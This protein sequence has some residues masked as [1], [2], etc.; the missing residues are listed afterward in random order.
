MRASLT[1]PDCSASQVLLRLLCG[2][3]L[4]S[5]LAA[6]AS[7]QSA[8]DGT[9]PAGLAPGSPAG[10]YALSDFDTVN[11]YNG[12]LNVRLPLL[13]VGG[14]GGA[15]YP[16]T[17]H[18]EQKWTVHREKIEPHYPWS[19]WAEPGWWSEEGTGWRTFDAG[20]LHV[21]RGGSENFVQTCGNYIHAKT[22]SRVTFSA[23]DGTEYELRDQ[24]TNGQPAAPAGCGPGFNRGRVFVTADGT[25]ATYVSDADVIDLY[26]YGEDWTVAPTSGYLLLRDGTRY[27][28]DDGK[29][30]WMRDRNGNLLTFTYDPY[31]RVTGVADSLGRQVTITYPSDGV[32]YTEIR[33]SGSGGAART[34]RVGQTNLGSALRSDFT[35]Q[36][37]QQLFPELNASSSLAHDPTVI[38]YVELPDGRRYQ[39]QYN[40]YGEV[41]RVV[42]PTGGAVE[43]DHAAG[44]TDGAASGVF[45]I[46]SHKYVYRR[47]VERR[48][49]PGGGTGTS[50]ASRMTYSRPETTGSNLGYVVADQYDAGGTLLGRS[51]HHYHGSPRASFGLKPTDYPAWK[52]GREYKTEVFGANGTTALRR[53]EHTFAQRAAVG[54]W[55]GDA[56]LAPPNDPRQVETVTTVEPDGASLVTKQTAISPQTGAVGFDQYNNQTDVWEYDYGTGAPGALARHTHTDYLTAG[57][58]GQAGPHIRNLPAA[59]SVRNGAGAV[60]AQSE[61]RYDEYGLTTYGAITGWSDPGTAARGNATTTRKWLDTSGTWLETH[62]AYDQ[63]GNAVSATD[64]RGNTSTVSY[65]DS[66]SDG[67]PRNTYALPTSTTSAVP[68]PTGTYGANTALTSSTVYDYWTGLVRSSTDANGRTTT[69][70]YDDPLDRLTSYSNPDGGWANI[71]YGDAPGDLF[72]NVRT[73]FDQTRFTDTYRRFDGLGRVWRTLSNEF[74]SWLKVDTQYDALGRVW[75][76]SN[77]FRT[78]EGHEGP[79]N[80]SGR[81]TTTQYDALGRVLTVTTPDNAAVTT[82]Y[83]GNQVT[84]TDQAGKARRSVSDALGRLT[85]VVEDPNYSAHVTNYLY[86]AL[87]NLR[88]VEQGGQYRHFMYDSLS[89]LTRA[90]NPEQEVNAAL[91]T[92]ADPVSGNSQWSLGYS[93]DNNGNLLTRTDAR[94]VTATYGYDNLNRNTTISYANDPQN[95]PGVKRIYDGAANGRGRY[96][97]DWTR[98]SDGTYATHR[99]VDDYDAMGR[100][101]SQRQYLYVNNQAG[102]PFNTARTYN[103]AGG[104]ESQTYPS[105]RTVTYGYDAAGRA[106]SL[107]GNLGDGAQRTYSTGIRYDEAGGLQQE[108]FGTQT[109]LYHKRH[110]NVRGQLYDVRLSTF[111]WEADQWNWNRGCLAFYYGGAPH[112]QSSTTNN[113]NLTRAQYWV[114][115]NE[116]LSDY[117]FY[118]DRYSYDQLNRLSSVAEYLGDTAVIT[119]PQFTQGYAYDRWGNRQIDAA[120]TWG[121]GIPEPQFAIDAATNRLGVPAGQGGVMQYDA[122][123]NLTSDSYTGAGGRTY[124][125]EHRMTSAWGPGQGGGT[126]QNQY[127]YDA[128]GRRVRRRAEAGEVWQVYGLD[129]EL[130]AEYAAGAA[131]SSPRKEYGYRN[132]ELLVVAD[133]AGGTP[134]PALSDDFNDDALDAAKWTVTAPNSPTT[135]SEQGQQLR[136]TLAPSTAGYNGVASAQAHDFRGKAAQVEVAQ[137][138]SQA[139][140]VEN[141]LDVWLNEQNYYWISAGAGSLAFRAVVGGVTDQSYVT[142]D[143]AAHR[144]WRIRH[145]QAANTVSFETSADGAAW[146]THKTVAAGFAL[147][148][149]SIYLGAGA[150]WTGNPA[151]GEARYDNFRLGGGA[152]SGAPEIK[153]L[154]SDHLGTPRMTVDQTGSLAGVRRH[155]Y[156][157]FGEEIGAGVGGRTQSQG[158][159]QPSGIRQGFTGYEKDGETGLNYAQARYHSPTQGRFTSVD[160]ENAGADLGVPQSWNGY[161]YVLNNPLSLVDPSGMIW[162]QSQEHGYYIWVANDKYKPE[163]YKGY[164]EV[165]DGSVIQVAG[166]SGQYSQFGNLVG[167]YATLNADGTLSA[168]PDETIQITAQED[169]YLYAEDFKREMRRPE[170]WDRAAGG[171]VWNVTLGRLLGRLFGRSSASTDTPGL[172][173]SAPKSLGRGNTG[174]TTPANLKEQLAM[175][176]VKSNPAAGSPIPLK[177]GMTDPRWPGSAGWVKMRQNVNGVEIHYVRNMATGEV[178]DFKFKN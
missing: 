128:D 169:R 104:V 81:W 8:T 33:F 58:D 101:R 99:A 64:A 46:D 178:D 103:Y 69:Y 11:P 10:S 37:P 22:L 94:N 105:G 2:L 9:T 76:V 87:G 74:G 27:R 28:V 149:V 68:D 114:P 106:S 122:A 163:D 111:S 71:R 147:E 39:F 75:R 129:G 45:A 96:W 123:G 166:V 143:A 85:Q 132:G 63:A 43:Y 146:Q 125:A 124:D 48:V 116:Q 130:L 40:N 86:D 157:P 65:A 6:G 140:W 168:A 152:G 77:Q 117:R 24:A 136:V 23:P 88:R 15:G 70:G 172:P 38:S 17:L 82:S 60:V 153:W 57:Y 1:A 174:R 90:R 162:L 171:A 25:S 177:G 176:Q 110:Y 100:P 112:G 61:V 91:N 73:M 120:Q 83:S 95:T 144:H 55:T 159:S 19:Y 93:Y 164:H 97:A 107:A 102:Q 79:L 78:P 14:R 42:L 32:Q 170:T 50:Y 158:Y 7:A 148:A 41:A 80:P 133:A 151:P 156:L 134:A 21:R 167:G 119:G 92:S 175:T 127:A 139:G 56:E 34:L 49:Y 115:F 18:V 44:L 62:A 142:Y 131:P 52:D 155:D 84:V 35:V 98:Y 47:V 141:I 145:D 113:G 121:A 137:A 67:V 138:V 54:W 126:Y 59:G 154:V 16:V 3:L 53:A 89:R 20:R 118:E 36:S 160:P 29:V 135:V 5:L 12:G 165:L 150:W 173:K 72:V 13:R 109:P 108:Q 4:S 161:A 30:S 51:H 26:Y 31:K 66:F